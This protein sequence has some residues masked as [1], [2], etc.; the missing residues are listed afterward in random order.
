MAYR[1]TADASTG[2]LVNGLEDVFRII[3]KAEAAIRD[4]S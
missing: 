3:L 1:R 2:T 4:D